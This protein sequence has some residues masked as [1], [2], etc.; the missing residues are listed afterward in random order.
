MFE[1]KLTL[2][3]IFSN[4]SD[5]VPHLTRS[6]KVREKYLKNRQ[7]SVVKLYIVK[8]NVH[9]L[10]AASVTVTCYITAVSSTFLES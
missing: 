1:A 8:R 3:G 6:D 9:A 5:S 10:P 4:W 2:T 7:S